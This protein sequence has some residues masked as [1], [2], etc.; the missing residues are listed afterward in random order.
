MLLPGLCLSVL[1]ALAFREK[2]GAATTSPTP[3]STIDEQETMANEVPSQQRVTYLAALAKPLVSICCVT[4]VAS[5]MTSTWYLSSLEAHLS[6]TLQVS[7]LLC[8]ISVI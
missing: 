8:N 3:N 7:T 6:I 2:A 1:S 5:G 4:M